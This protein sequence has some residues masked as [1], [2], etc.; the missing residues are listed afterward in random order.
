MDLIA[1]NLAAAYPQ[2]DEHAGINIVPMKEDTVGDVRVTL[3]V[4]MGAVGF[5]LLIACTNVANLLLARS[6]LR[7]REFAIRRALGA[8]RFRLIRQ[9]LTESVLLAVVGAILGLVIAHWST[10]G[11][12]ASLPA[13]FPRTSEIRL[14]VTVLLFT[15]VSAV[16]TGTAFGVGASSKNLRR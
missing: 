7:S 10:K 15:L 16:L 6:I 9:S 12:L 4:L 8:Q 2:E 13:F 5:V 11:V 3:L 1:H 14:D